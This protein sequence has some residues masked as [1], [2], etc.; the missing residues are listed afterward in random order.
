MSDIKVFL[1]E[2]EFVIREGIKSQI[3]WK[4]N[5][6]VFCGEAS[7]GELAL[8][9][10]REKQPDIVITDIRMPFMDG[11]EMSAILKREFPWMEIL[12]LTGYEEFEYARKGLEIGVARYLTKPVSGE[13]LLAEVKDLADKILEKREERE[14]QNTYVREMEEQLRKERRDFFRV[15][16][17]G[18]RN[19]SEIMEYAGKL[20]LAVSAVWYNLVLLAVKSARHLS[21]EFSKLMVR[22][23]EKIGTMENRSCLVF[24]RGLEGKA[25]LLKGSS[26]EDLAGN[27][28]E[29]LEKLTEVLNSSRDIRYF[30]GVGRP[31]NRL[32]SMNVCFEEASRALAHRYLIHQNR[33]LDCAELDRQMAAPA[34]MRQLERIDPTQYRR[35]FILDYLHTGSAEEADRFIGEFFRGVGKETM[36]SLLFRQYVAMDMYILVANFAEETGFGKE[37]VNGLEHAPKSAV[38][39]EAVIRYAS[40]IIR[41]AIRQRD[42]NARNQYHNV[43]AE[44]L[45]YI[46]SHYA[47]EELSLNTLAAHVNFSPNHLSTI[48]SQETGKTFIR[49]LT[50]YRMRR[51]RELL[52][53]SGKKS[54]I[55]SQEVGYRDPHYFSYLF[56]KTQGMTPTQ[57]RSG[58]DGGSA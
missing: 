21:G 35:E 16:I 33:I 3:D 18:D 2:D 41:E 28:K 49:Y 30:G 23:D 20:D 44:A 14:I 24:D 34:D 54:S 17:T 39:A 22:I 50:D 5:G 9:L 12:L 37:Q 31:V 27:Q 40:E 6:L 47:D 45:R 57:Y 46:D 7:D 43:V 48:F 8:P 29:L 19:V 32:S 11:L 26:E 55:I 13:E 15:L 58:E 36:D 10:I 56:K 51:A 52:R 25:F 38:S 4:G 42:R 1:V 53:S